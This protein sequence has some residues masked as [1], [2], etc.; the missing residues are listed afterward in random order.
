MGWWLAAGSLHLGQMQYHIYNTSFRPF[1]P[2]GVIAVLLVAIPPN[3]IY[4]LNL[5]SRCPSFMASWLPE[6]GGP[7]TYSEINENELTNG[8]HSWAK[9][10]LAN[11]IQCNIAVFRG[12][13]WAQSLRFALW[14][15]ASQVA[16]ILRSEQH[17]TSFALLAGLLQD[18]YAIMIDRAWWMLH[19]HHHPCFHILT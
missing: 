6:S 8:Q 17:W 7:Y 15:Q 5:N 9:A 11:L 2:A 16:N 18:W 3:S 19:N 1:R 12:R 10:R 4:R 13:Y 14:V